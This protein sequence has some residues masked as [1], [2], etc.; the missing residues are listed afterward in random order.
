M[1]RLT[2]FTDRAM[3]LG[4]IGFNHPKLRS[5]GLSKR[6]FLTGW[7]AKTDSRTQAQ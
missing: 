1:L 2:K 7:A 3:N 5:R 6:V 4:V